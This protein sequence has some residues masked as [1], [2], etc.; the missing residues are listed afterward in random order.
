MTL[1][2]DKEESFE[3]NDENDSKTSKSFKTK[4]SISLTEYKFKN[5]HLFCFLLSIIHTVL[6]VLNLLIE[7]DLEKKDKWEWFYYFTNGSEGFYRF[8]FFGIHII[9]IFCSMPYLCLSF[10]K[11]KIS[12]HIFL[13][14]YSIY[15][16]INAITSLL[17]PLSL[18]LYIYFEIKE[19]FII[20][21]FAFII[22]IF[23]TIKFRLNCFYVQFI[24]AE[25][26]KN[27]CNK[28][29]SG[30]RIIFCCQ[31]ISEPN[32]V[33]LNSG[34]IYHS[35]ANENDFVQDLSSGESQE[36]QEK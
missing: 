20:I 32:F 14:T 26:G 8:A 27:L 10:N 35:L 34:F 30:L 36:N 16:I 23:I 3:Y 12:E 6:Y 11:E 5:F 19:L 21:L 28:L 7:D 31:K 9:F 25:N 17:F 33:D 4:K 29:I 15:C 24:L 22:H 18:L 2:K 1:N 13:N